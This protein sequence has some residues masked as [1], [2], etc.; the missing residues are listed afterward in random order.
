MPTFRY[1]F[2]I[3][4]LVPEVLCGGFDLPVSHPLFRPFDGSAGVHTCHGPGLLDNASVRFQD[5]PLPRRLARPGILISG[6][7][8][9]EGLSALALSGARDSRQPV[10]E[11]LDFYSV[12]RLSGDAASDVSL[13]GFPDPQTCPEAL[14][15]RTRL[16]VLSSASPCDL[17]LTAGGDVL[18]VNSRSRSPALYAVP[19]A[20]A[21]C[22]GLSFSGQRPRLLGRL[23]PV[24]S[25]VMVCRLPSTG[26]SSSGHSSAMSLPLH[27]RLQLRL[28]CFL[29]RRPSVRLV[30]SALY[31]IFHQPPET[32]GGALCGSGFPFPFGESLGRSLR[33]QHHGVG[34]SQE[35]GWDAFSDPQC[36]SPGHLAA[37]RVP[38]DPP[39]STVYSGPS[40]CPSGV[41]QSEVSGQSGPFAA[42]R[43]RNFIVVGQPLSISLRPHSAII[44]RST[45][46]PWWIL[47]QRGRMRCSSPGMAY[48]R[49]PF[50]PSGCFLVSSPRFG[51]RGG[52]S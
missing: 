25:S 35:T 41:P 22:G 21:E 51:S 23:L 30:V 15:S 8:A 52:W 19:S 33:R 34:L 44:C 37:V 42:R 12:D 3:F 2:I 38:S 29:R 16:H 39:A 43:F 45:F 50:P 4:S 48:R 9:G 26:R 13:E 49:M 1:R 14:L 28:G 17:A 7:C 20:V 31:H 6:D 18:G 27:G 24:G 47:S 5:P 10:E 40:Q 36:H 32:A 46:L 11:L